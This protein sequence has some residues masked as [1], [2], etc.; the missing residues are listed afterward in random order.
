[1]N[2]RRKAAE[3]MDGV[4]NASV[5]VSDAAALQTIVI[6]IIGIGVIFAIVLGVKALSS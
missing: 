1:M 4:Q 6:G 5:K 3:T 2:L